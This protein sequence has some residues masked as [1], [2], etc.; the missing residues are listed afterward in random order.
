[1]VYLQLRGTVLYI[2]EPHVDYPMHQISMYKGS[3]GIASDHPTESLLRLK[4]SNGQYLL[5]AKGLPEIISWFEHLQA[6]VNISGDLD[7]RRMPRIYTIRRGTTTTLTVG[8]TQA[9]I[10]ILSR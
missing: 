2:Y 5:R 6:S 10:P 4:L 8:K 7:R 9:V 3:C 1:M